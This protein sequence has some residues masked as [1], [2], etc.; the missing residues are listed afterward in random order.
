MTAR[1]EFLK[2]EVPLVPDSP[3][4]F[5]CVRRSIGEVKLLV[6]T[7]VGL[8][9]AKLEMIADK[10]RILV[11]DSPRAYSTPAKLDYDLIVFRPG[12][13]IRVENGTSRCGRRSPDAA[14]SG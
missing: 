6:E 13:E 5:V 12:G 2:A 8:A 14:R 10:N 4:E 11:V 7:T 3:Q 1:E 9:M